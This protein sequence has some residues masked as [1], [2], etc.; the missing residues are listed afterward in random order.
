MIEFVFPYAFLLLPLPYLVYRFWAAKQQASAALFM[1]NHIN[2]T[3]LNS[4]SAPNK[5]NKLQLLWACLFWLSLLF[6]LA[7]PVKLGDAINLPSVARDLLLA[8]DIS[9]SM[10]ERDMLVGQNQVVDRL[11]ATKAVISDF[12]SS[13]KGDRVGLILYGTEAFMQAPL[14]FD[15][16]TVEQLL[17]EAQSGFAGEY[18]A[19]GDAI[20]LAIKKLADQPQHHRI[21]ILL[22][23]GENTAGVLS[24][25]KAAE[26]AQQEH[27]QIY[28]IALGHP[29]SRSRVDETTLQQIAQVTGGQFFRARNPKELQAIYQRINSLEPIEQATTVYRPQI[30]LY[31]W[32]LGL[33]MF[34][35][36]LMLMQLLALPGQSRGK[37]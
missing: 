29:R 16:N 10:Q 20:G 18:T 19:I 9:G 27:I 7:K 17:N 5:P 37:V 36:L 26:F 23:D 13:R 31:Y 28:T 32:P 3:L 25:E 21:V 22:S 34:F 6:A 15:I 24:P 8:V 1:P 14:T 35:L 30:P 33:A 2:Q 12:L 4:Q 11:T